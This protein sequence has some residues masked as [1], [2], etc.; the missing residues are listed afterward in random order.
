MEPR[1]DSFQVPSKPFKK[2][3]ISLSNLLIGI[4]HA[5]ADAWHPGAQEPAAVAE[6]LHPFRVGGLVLSVVVFFSEFYVWW[7]FHIS[8]RYAILRF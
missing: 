8:L 3:L 5:A 1:L 2:S 4:V 6:T 7:L